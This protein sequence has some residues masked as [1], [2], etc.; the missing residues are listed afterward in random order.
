MRSSTSTC[1]MS[2]AAVTGV[3]VL[4]KMETDLTVAGRVQACLEACME[5]GKE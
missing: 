1:E 3:S 5:R 4:D 2:V